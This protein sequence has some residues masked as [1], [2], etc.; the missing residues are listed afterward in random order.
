MSFKN[1]DEAKRIVSYPSIVRKRGLRVVKSDS[2]RLKYK[3]DIGCPFLCLIS[4]VK[5]GQGF[6]IKTLE[7]KHTCQEAFK[8]KRATQQA[9]AH[10]FKNKVQ[11]N[12]KYK[13]KDMRK[14]V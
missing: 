7:T 4:E 3:C 2:T 12:P 8:N 9:L 11:N 5:K 13:V 1:L 6:E 14:D 10:Y